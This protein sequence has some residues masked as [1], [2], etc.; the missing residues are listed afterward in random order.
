MS[1][2]QLPVPAGSVPRAPGLVA[3]EPAPEWW[4]VLMAETIPVDT[5][6]RAWVAVRDSSLSTLGQRFDLIDREGVLVG[7]VRVPPRYVLVGFGAA[8]VF[9]GRLDADDLLSLQRYALP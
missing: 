8:H 4:P 2:A 3:P 6:D 7:A 5:R 1:M 9:V